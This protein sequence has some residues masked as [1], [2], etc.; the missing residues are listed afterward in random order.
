VGKVLVVGSYAV[1]LML[2]TDS[3]PI[4]GETRRGWGYQEGPGGKGSNQAIGIARLGGRAEL[5]ACVGDDRFGRAA[6]RMYAEEG[7]DASRVKVMAGVS[8]G[9]GFIVID[10]TGQNIIVLDPGANALLDADAVEG[11][12]GDIG[13]ED[14][15]LAQLEIPP[16]IA[17]AAMTIGRRAGARTILNPAPATD[18]PADLGSIDVLIPNQSELRVL[19]GRSPRDPAD[20]LVLARV[21]LD[22][23][24]GTVVVT[25]GAEG[26]LIVRPD[27][28]LVVRA[29]TV[30]VVDSTGAGDAFNAAFAAELARGAS[31]EE[32]VRSAV[33]AGALACTRFGV[34][35]SLP[36][37]A[38]LDKAL[39]MWSS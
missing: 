18:L 37:R 4:P 24:V 33:A 2:Q 11:A 22:R 39:A 23:G 12:A 16:G 30:D 8:T 28:A 1:G 36:T 9:I 27:G 20:D 29:P 32:A 21:L 13:E 34:V 14:V 19:L 5:I 3:F 35:P 31:T 38:E 15:V 26:A 17:L 7:V 25:R 6:L 10:K